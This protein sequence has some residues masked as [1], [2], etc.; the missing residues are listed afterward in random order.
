MISTIHVVLGVVVLILLLYGWRTL[1]VAYR[2][3][4]GKM[5]V[6]CPETDQTVGVSVD[7]RRAAVTAAYLKPELRLQQCT[8]WP[9]RQDCGQECL[10]RIEASPADCLV[11]TML[12]DWYRERSCAFCGTGF[13]QVGSYDHTLYF[14]YDKRPAL[15]SSDGKLVEWLSMPV[16]ALPQALTTHKPVCW[17][18][19]IAQ[20]FRQKYPELVVDR[21]AEWAR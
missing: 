20:T 9:E 15:V 12:T 11:R 21:P 18:C 6:T 13:Q 16:E 3:Y 4:R 19:L 14:G 5:L 10:S 7:T 17:N 2:T 1:I 8:R